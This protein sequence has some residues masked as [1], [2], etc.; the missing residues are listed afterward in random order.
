MWSIIRYY[1]AIMK[2]TVQNMKS[3]RDVHLNTSL[4]ASVKLS[5]TL[6]IFFA[7]SLDPEQY[8]RLEIDS[9]WLTF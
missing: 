4:H 7:N 9:N 5:Q 1:A 6:L 2:E 3:T 8:V